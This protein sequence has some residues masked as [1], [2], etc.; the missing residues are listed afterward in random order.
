MEELEARLNAIT[1]RSELQNEGV[2]RPYPAE[3]DAAPYPSKFE[4]LTLQTFDGTGSP[5]QH[6]Y[7]FKS[8]TGNVISNDAILAR[9]FIGTLKGVSF[10]W[11]RKL[12]AGCIQK[13]ADLERLFLSRFFEEDTEVSIHT[14]LATKQKKRESVKAFVK[15]FRTMALRC[16]S[17]M[18]QST[19]VETCRHNLQTD[20]LT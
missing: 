10:E 12:P 5:N 7:H 14:L 3:W 16:S 15:R 4:V 1:N 11:F 17:G 6:I 2:V 18:T 8:Q 13:W 20:L 19:L 9:L